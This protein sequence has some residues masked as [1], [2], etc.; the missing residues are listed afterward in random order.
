MAKSLCLCVYSLVTIKQPRPQETQDLLDRY[1]LSLLTK[2]CCHWPFS[3][4]LYIG[5]SSLSQM[6]KLSWLVPNLWTNWHDAS[7]NHQSPSVQSDCNTGDNIFVLQITFICNYVELENYILE[8]RFCLQDCIFL[9]FWQNFNTKRTPKMLTANV[10]DSSSVF[11]LGIEN[12]HWT[13]INSTWTSFVGNRVGGEQIGPFSAAYLNDKI[14]NASMSV[15]KSDPSH[16][17][18]FIDLF[19][20]S[21]ADLSV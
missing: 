16:Q 15:L 21:L 19:C 9:C 11:A 4:Q 6:E 18:W 20:Q 5:T 14:S 12:C 2:L 10:F 3:H 17:R 13:E 7:S 8:R 1:H